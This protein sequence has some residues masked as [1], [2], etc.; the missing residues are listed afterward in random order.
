MTARKSTKS[1]AA[2][3]PRKKKLSWSDVKA[4]IA[5]FER[6]ALIG[7]ISDLYAYNT[8]T[9]TSCMPDFRSAAIHSSRTRKLLTMR[10]FPMSCPMTML[11]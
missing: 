6:P 10:F 11:K 3:K 9:K 1:T 5:N 8:S 7:L 4:A 2:A